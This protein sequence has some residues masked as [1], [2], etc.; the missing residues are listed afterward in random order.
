M[1]S[2]AA[3]LTNP[4]DLL[5]FCFV[6]HRSRDNVSDV[7]DSIRAHYPAAPVLLSCDGGGNFEDL[8]E[9][10]RCY[11][12]YYPVTIGRHFS[13]IFKD[14][15]SLTVAE[16]RLHQL[17]R[18]RRIQ[19]AVDTLDTEYVVFIEDDVR[20]IR[21]LAEINP[22]DVAGPCNVK[23]HYDRDMPYYPA[24]LGKG[25]ARKRRWF[26]CGGCKI[27]KRSSW[28]RLSTEFCENSEALFLEFGWKPS[29]I[30]VR[31]RMEDWRRFA[32]SDDRFDG[33]LALYLGFSTGHAY[34]V[35][36]IPAGPERR[37]CIH[38]RDQAAYKPEIHFVHQYKRLY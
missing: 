36:Y 24:L 31:D 1:Q 21:P 30:A 6:C 38:W 27:W 37:R 18:H 33:L 16:L 13:S 8:C 7:L 25:V 12:D 14:K 10:H 11:W 3:P 19:K 26:N 17:E 34:G 9:R 5:G 20:C 23:N 22:V 2:M 28:N 29:D 15:Q 35:W 32:I 4:D